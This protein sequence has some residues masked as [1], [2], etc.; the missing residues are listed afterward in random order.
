MLPFI[1]IHFLRTFSALT[2]LGR[3]QGGHLVCKKT[4]W[5]GAG[6]IICLGPGADLHMGQLMPLPLTSS[7]PS[8]SRLVLPEWFCLSGTGLLGFWFFFYKE[9][10]F[11]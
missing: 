5:W 4:E 6:M 2:L 8:K 3:Q 7:F 1:P 9:K 11:F 10:G